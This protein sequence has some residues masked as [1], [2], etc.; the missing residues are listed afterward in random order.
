MTDVQFLSYIVLIDK[1]LSAGIKSVIPHLNDGVTTDK[2][3]PTERTGYPS[4]Y[5]LYELQNVLFDN[6]HNLRIVIN[7]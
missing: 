6:A 5:E 7:K 2:G 3:T 1:L 4:L